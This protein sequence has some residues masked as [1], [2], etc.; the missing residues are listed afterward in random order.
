[1]ESRNAPGPSESGPEWPP[2]VAGKSRG[3]GDR[4]K[5][6]CHASRFALISH[7]TPCGSY[8]ILTS[9]PSSCARPRSMSREPNPFRR[10]GTTG[11]PS[12]SVGKRAVLHGIRRE[13]VERHAD[14]QGHL[15][16]KPHGRPVDRK[17]GRIGI[18]VGNYRLCSDVAEIGTLP[19]FISQDVV[20]A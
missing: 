14:R 13:L 6:C 3:K 12:F 11:G 2:A 18:T 4:R 15:G 20:R 16:R 10:G 19:A 8:S 5:R 7:Q 9:P 17:T 1:M